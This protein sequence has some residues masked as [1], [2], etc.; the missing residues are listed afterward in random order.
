M[1]PVTRNLRADESSAWGTLVVLRASLPSDIVL[2]MSPHRD[3][4]SPFKKVESA[5]LLLLGTRQALGTLPILTNGAKGKNRG[6]AAAAVSLAV[7]QPPTLPSGS[8]RTLG[9]LQPLGIAAPWHRVRALPVHSSQANG[10]EIS[11]YKEQLIRAEKK[12]PDQ[13]MT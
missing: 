1:R 12:S 6:T 7:D 9:S 5:S 13:I 4:A 2:R 11:G 3:T 8:N 10:A